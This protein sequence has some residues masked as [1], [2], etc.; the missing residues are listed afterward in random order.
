M[1]NEHYSVILSTNNVNDIG[2]PGGGGR[3]G[4][5]GGNG[6][7]Q[8]SMGGFSLAKNFGEE[9]EKNKY[10]YQPLR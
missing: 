9:I 8:S 6:M 1:D 7:N 5:G 4:R 10:R 2:F 3:G